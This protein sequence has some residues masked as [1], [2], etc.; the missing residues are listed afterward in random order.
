Y[1]AGGCDICKLIDE[2]IYN[3]TIIDPF[4]PSQ[5]KFYTP[6]WE[7]FV[8]NSNSHNGLSDT[9]IFEDQ[10]ITLKRSV[11]EENGSFEAKLSTGNV[12]SIPNSLTVWEVLDMEKNNKPLGTIR[13]ERRFCNEQDFV[14]N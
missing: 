12:C 2:E 14:S 11:Y 10:R 13:I 5:E 8:K 3:I 1:I 6:E 4:L 9:I 7:W